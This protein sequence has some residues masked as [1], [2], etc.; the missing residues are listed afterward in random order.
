MRKTIKK[1]SSINYK[2][3]DTMA[4]SET[5]EPRQTRAIEKKKKIVQVAFKLFCEKGFHHTN[6]N[7]IAK[8]AGVSTG[9]VYHYFKDKKAIFLAVMDQVIPKFDDDMIK[10]LHLSKDRKELEAFL[11]DIIDKDVQLHEISRV[12]H[13]EFHAMRHSDPDV[14]EYMNNF[15]NQFLSSI[16]GALPSLGFSISHPQEKVDM[17]YHMIDQYSDS[18]VLNKRE[19][20]NYDVMKKLLIET[21]FNLLDLDVFD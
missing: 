15:N 18:I 8:E 1:H 6:T 19:K 3:E 17:I 16:A 2:R 21:I 11:S 10:Q 13:E 5:R 14:A 20:I 12:A 4:K 9:I 7:E